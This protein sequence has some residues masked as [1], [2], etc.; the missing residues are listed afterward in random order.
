MFGG[1]WQGYLLPLLQ[2]WGLFRRRGTSG[3]VE[4]PMPFPLFGLL[5]LLVVAGA[6]VLS[7]AFLVPP[8]A[9]PYP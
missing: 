3:S 4:T 7:L 5:V 1:F 6:I 8:G 9:T 2:S